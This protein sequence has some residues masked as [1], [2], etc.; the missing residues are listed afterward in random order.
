MDIISFEK[1]DSTN[2][3][4]KENIENLADKTVIS[5]DCQTNGYGQ[6]QRV[7]V[8]AGSEN[9]YMTFVLKPSDTLQEVH[10]NLTQ[11]LAVVVCEQLN[12]LMENGKCEEDAKKME[13]GKWKME[14]E[15]LSLRGVNEVSDAAIQKE[16][17][18]SIKAPNDVL[19]NG[20]KV[21]GILAESITKGNK[22]KGIVLGIG[23]N[24]N[25][26]AENLQ[27]IDQ[28]ATS[29]SLELG[30]KINKQE[31]MQKLIENFFANYDEFLKKGFEYIKNELEVR[32]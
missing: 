3:Y 22:L 4:A 28:P 21:A 32:S 9:V 25:S 19:V 7:W 30:Q 31:F 17:C 18:V 2:K 29:V 1:L 11:Y 12:T 10:A 27:T 6:F 23:I 24:L 13:N 16:I 14:N 20:K 5:A 8:D 15:E 26:A